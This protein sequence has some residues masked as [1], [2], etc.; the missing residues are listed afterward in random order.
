ML[1]SCIADMRRVML[2]C[3][4]EVLG[5]EVNVAVLLIPRRRFSFLISSEDVSDILINS[6]EGVSTRR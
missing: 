4:S 3:S 5:Y 1:P 6:S 2:E